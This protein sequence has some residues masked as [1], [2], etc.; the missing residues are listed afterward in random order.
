MSTLH[1]VLVEPQI[2]QNTGNIARTCAATNA[3]LHLVEP[4]GF[5]LDDK[6][7]KRAGLD[8]WHFLDIRHYDSLDDF[9]A[10]NDGPF[11]YFTTKG[12][13]RYSDV[14]YQVLCEYKDRLEMFVNSRA[15]EMMKNAKQCLREQTFCF[16]N[17]GQLI[18]G[19]FDVLC[20]DE[21]SLSI[22]DYKTDRVSKYIKNEELVERH[23]FQ[24]NL[25][26][27]ALRSIYPNLKI[28]AYLYYLEI[29][30]LVKV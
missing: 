25:Y 6:K 15:F 2:P 20:V 10:K 12:R 13:H 5:K 8:Y 28:K 18:H 23:A 19:T 29:G 14:E 7:L 22:I 30:R 16:M 11:Y 17:E 26:K 3:V 1:I 27:K 24:L 9:F 21:D 4:M